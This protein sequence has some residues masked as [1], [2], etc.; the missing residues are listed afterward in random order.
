MLPF[1][2]DKMVGAA[3]DKLSTAVHWWYWNLIPFIS[4]SNVLLIKL[5]SELKK[6]ALSLL[7]TFEAYISSGTIYLEGALPNFFFVLLK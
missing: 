4:K 2:T 5:N 3:G 7:C 1:I 6:T